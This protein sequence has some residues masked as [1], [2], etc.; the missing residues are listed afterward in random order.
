MAADDDA[1]ERDLTEVGDAVA[2]VEAELV[3]DH[4]QNPPEDLIEAVLDAYLENGRLVPAKHAT[5]SALRGDTRALERAR[6]LDKLRASAFADS[7]LHNYGYGVTA[8]R[9]WCRSEGVPALPFDPLNVATHLI[10]YAFSWAESS[11]E[12]RRDEDGNPVNAVVVGTVDLRLAS[13][14]KAA[15]FLGMP[16]PGDNEG[17]RELM[18]GLRRTFLSAREH[19]KRALTHDLLLRCLE[20][21]TGRTLAA[22]RVRA[23]L[24]LRAR[25]SATAGQL[26][27][28]S[29]ADLTLTAGSVTVELAPAHRH[30]RS[31]Q[32]V[33]AA[34]PTNPTVCLVETLRALRALSPRLDR[35]FT[36]P[37]GMPLTRQALHL[38]VH[39]AAASAGGW[40]AVP[41]LRDREL[42][43]LMADGAGSTPLQSARDR[44]LLLTGFWGAL[45]RSNLSALNWSDLV[46]HGEDGIE[47]ILRKSKTDQ[48]GVG[49]SVW[50]PPSEPGS[51]TPCPATALRRWHTQLTAAMGRAPLPDEPVFVSLTGGGTV[52]INGRD[53]AA[54]LSGEGINEVVQRLTVAAGLTAKPKRG[55]RNPFGAHSLRAGFVTEAPM[56]GM[57]IPEIMGVTKHK[58]PQ[59]VMEYVRLTRAAKHNTSRRLLGQL[60]RHAA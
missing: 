44:A 16:K 7:T 22:Q 12:V 48:E 30:G 41:G 8:W 21:T 17:V 37:N 35:L 47:V 46:D 60:G 55:D 19:Q 38:A 33:I 25:T 51:G 10:D 13:L 49:T 6:M 2:I 36:H 34:H 28:L 56:A 58:S 15:E 59:I 54:R 39:K 50:A 27:S 57:S 9:D 14:N 53:R 32:V 5:P 3:G 20:A 18:R 23:A 52:R 24:L 31:R 43:G 26:E 1:H 40:V 29:W 4:Q 45:R 42:A 11:Q